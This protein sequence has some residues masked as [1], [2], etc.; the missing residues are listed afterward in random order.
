MTK[1]SDPFVDKLTLIYNCNEATSE[2]IASTLRD[3]SKDHDFGLHGYYR[4][5]RGL[6]YQYAFGLPIGDK[7]QS[8]CI[9]FVLSNKKWPN[10][11]IEWNPNVAKKYGNE[12]IWNFIFSFMLED[13]E[14][15]LLNALITRL[16]IAIDIHP[17]HLDNIWTTA[18]RY[19]KS[20]IHYGEGGRIESIYL[21]SNESDKQIKLYDKHLEQTK[22]GINIPKNTVRIECRLSPKISIYDLSAV[23]N[24]FPDCIVDAIPDG[25]I[26]LRDYDKIHFLDSIRLRGLHNALKLITPYSRRKYHAW[27]TEMTNSDWWEPERVW[28]NWDNA[29]NTLRLPERPSIS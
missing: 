20:N 26:R 16:D 13:Y 24:P 17:I 2:Y 23:V 5:Y 28:Q 6:G 9:I 22:K 21:G 8:E 11:R 1:L 4:N 14:D 27:I 15:F 25:D 7:N 29:I 10:L 19:R 18:A 12:F 3:M